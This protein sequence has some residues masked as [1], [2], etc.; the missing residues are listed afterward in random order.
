MDL[1]VGVL[2][3][4]PDLQAVNYESQQINSARQKRDRKRRAFFRH[5]GL[6]IIIRKGGKQKSNMAT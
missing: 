1:Q 2:P 3:L 4:E 6:A 5:C